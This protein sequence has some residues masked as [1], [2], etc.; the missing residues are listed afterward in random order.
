[1]ADEYPTQNQERWLEFLDRLIAARFDGYL[2]METR[3][4]DIVRDAK[5]LKRYRQAGIIHVYVGLE[6]TDQQTLDTIKKELSLDVSGECLQLLREHG[7]VSE[8]AFVLG[9]PWENKESIRATLRLSQTYDPDF[10]HYLAI[11]PWPYADIYEEMKPHIVVDDYRKY[12][13]IDPIIKPEQMTLAQVDRAIVSCYR[14][15]YMGKLKQLDREPDPFRKRYLLT[16]MRL[17]M[18]SSFLKQ[19][20]G[21]LGRIPAEVDRLLRRLSRESEG[22]SASA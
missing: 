15:F 19:K 22:G 20:M 3:A 16:S 8:T 9:F 12:N 13:L 2:L 14:D 4:P 11:T 1:V 5:F 21:S 18:R 10:A 7:M 17:M 6:A